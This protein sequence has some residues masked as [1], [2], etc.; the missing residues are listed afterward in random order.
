MNTTERLLASHCLRRI[1]CKPLLVG[2]DADAYL[3][4]IPT[5]T[6]L[7]EILPQLLLDCADLVLHASFYGRLSDFGLMGNSK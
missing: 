5:L 1:D 3:S 7:I 6:S 4:A 2:E